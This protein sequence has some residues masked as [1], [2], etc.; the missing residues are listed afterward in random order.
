MIYLLAAVSVALSYIQWAAYGPSRTNAAARPGDNPVLDGYL[1]GVS[2]GIAW[3]TVF[4]A[5]FYYFLS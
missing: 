1:A 3:C 5:F 4:V 2:A